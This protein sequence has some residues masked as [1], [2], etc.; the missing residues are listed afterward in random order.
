MILLAL[1]LPLR[2]A[3]AG[4]RCRERRNSGAAIVS[5]IVAVLFNIPE[6]P[7]TV[8]VDIPVTAAALAVSV[9]VLTPVVLAGLND[10]VTPLGR[11]DA[12]RLTL[13]LKPPCGPTVIVLASP[14][15]V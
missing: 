12:A 11:P 13:P 2:D 14:P 9:K 10:A 7:V 5:A 15:P 8:I 1:L 3:E 6:V 4:W